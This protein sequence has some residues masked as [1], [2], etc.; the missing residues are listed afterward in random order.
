MMGFRLSARLAAGAGALA[1]VGVGLTAFLFWQ[2]RGD[3]VG[4]MASAV[5]TGVAL[6]L[7]L[8]LFWLGRTLRRVDMNQRRAAAAE[9]RLRDAI[10]SLS[11]GFL[12]WDAADR[13]AMVNPAAQR[14]EARHGVGAPAAL[15]IGAT[16]EDL[17]R[18]RGQGRG[19][20][21]GARTGGA[22]IPGGGDQHR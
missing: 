22:H 11:D 14:A 17:L 1:V 9:A 6:V 15:E 5:A 19:P 2:V 20:S 13:L 12:L 3:Q 7:L 10:E 4:W 16:F 21:G 18:R 8:L